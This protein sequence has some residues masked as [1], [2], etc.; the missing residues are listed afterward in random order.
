MAENQNEFKLSLTKE[1]PG[2]INSELPDKLITALDRNLIA[3]VPFGKC[4]CLGVT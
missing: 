1:K 2:F 3:T 4:L